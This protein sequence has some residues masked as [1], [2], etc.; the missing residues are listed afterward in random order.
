MR[1]RTIF[2][3]ALLS[4]C[5]V[6]GTP[7]VAAGRKSGTSAAAKRRAGRSVPKSAEVP[8]KRDFDPVS[9]SSAGAT[10]VGGAS[11]ASSGAPPPSHG[12]TRLDFDD[13]LIQGQTN[14]SGAV[15]LYDRKE[16]KNRSMLKKRESFRSEIIGAV[17][18]DA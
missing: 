18:D 8:T 11:T 9:A 5:A 6:G 14:K 7:A 1:M 12:P 3:A 17:F 10:Q 13:R 16:L 15:Y 4:V 2:L